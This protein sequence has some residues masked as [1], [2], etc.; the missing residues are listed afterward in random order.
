MN[1]FKEVIFSAIKT[2]HLK[3]RL[4]FRLLGLP[5]FLYICL[6][7]LSD[8]ILDLIFRSPGLGEVIVSNSMFVITILLIKIVPVS[9]FIYI[10]ILVHRIILIKYV[11]S[12]S[13]GKCRHYFR[14]AWKAL[15]ISVL[16]WIIFV[17]LSFPI[18]FLGM[19][20]QVAVMLITV[21]M[22]IFISF[23]SLVLPATAIGRKMFFLE[24]VILASNNKVLM[25]GVS[26]LPIIFVSVTIYLLSLFHF[27]PTI[28]WVIDWIVHI[29]LL[30]FQVL[31]LSVAYHLIMKDQLKGSYKN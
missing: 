30:V 1:D 7:V 10:G 20:N 13:A 15:L 27:H 25:V 24:S 22:A 18:R 4:F 29:L 19:N 2:L 26:C 3:R 21:L 6:T 23:F 5:I 31:F 28:F 9:L 16:C 12:M 14:F 17:T 11:P 8:L